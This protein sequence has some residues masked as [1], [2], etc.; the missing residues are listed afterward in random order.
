MGIVPFAGVDVCLQDYSTYLQNPEERRKMN[1]P[2]ALGLFAIEMMLVF[3]T[4]LTFALF[5]SQ[6][7]K[8]ILQIKMKV[9][10]ND[11]RDENG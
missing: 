4:A 9:G 6:M 7:F 8:V 3:A 11:R 1:L 2:D 5:I 10:K